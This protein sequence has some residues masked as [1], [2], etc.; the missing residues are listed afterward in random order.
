LQPHRPGVDYKILLLPESKPRA[1]AYIGNSRQHADVVK[2]YVD[3]MCGKGFMRPSKSAWAAPVIVVKNPGGGLRICV[4]YRGLNELTIKNRNAPLL[5]RETLSRLFNAKWFTK[6]DIIAAFNEIRIKEGHEHM[7]AF[8]TRYSLYEYCVMP[9]GL[10]NAPATWQQYINHVLHKY[11]DVFCTAFLD[12]ILIY[13]ENE[14]DHFKHV[15]KVLQALREANL[16]L[17]VD[18]C[19]F[20]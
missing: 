18:K 4:D 13:S 16:F 9:F 3:K 15:N 5:I 2:A 7:T 19:E 6:F 1:K 17:D 11:L 10:T 14:S 20:C 12:D 8:L